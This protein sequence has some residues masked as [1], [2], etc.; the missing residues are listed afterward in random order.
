MD[1]IT[2][3]CLSYELGLNGEKK[4]GAN[5]DITKNGNTEDDTFHIRK[6]WKFW[7]FNRG[8][9]CYDIVTL[10]LSEEESQCRKK[11]CS[12]FSHPLDDRYGASPEALG[13]T[14][15]RW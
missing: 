14:R 12:Y 1:K 9:F 11:G 5:W 4:F 8:R 2:A 6:I 13:P 3:S 7:Q 10:K 15:H